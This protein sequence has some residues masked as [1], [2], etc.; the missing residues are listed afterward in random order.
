MALAR[1]A[2]PQA[3]DDRRLVV[4][5]LLDD[6]RDAFGARDAEQRHRVADAPSRFLASSRAV[7]VMKP[8]DVRSVGSG[9]SRWM[10][11]CASARC[12]RRVRASAIRAV[13]VL[14][15]R[16]TAGLRSYV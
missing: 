10:Y 16:F 11:A 4:A 7:D 6:V 2:Q 14:A 13:W 12:I 8:S 1:P 3:I 5:E 9:A 15:S